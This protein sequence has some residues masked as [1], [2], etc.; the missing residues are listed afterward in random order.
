VG[1]KGKAG[2]KKKPKLVQGNVLL[3]IITGTIRDKFELASTET[4]YPD[5]RDNVMGRRKI[6]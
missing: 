1:K 6:Y 2:R 5:S 4:H 3:R